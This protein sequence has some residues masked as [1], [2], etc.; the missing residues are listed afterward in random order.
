M[1]E[2]SDPI[3]HP[4]IYRTIIFAFAVWGAHFIASY[5]GVL[6]FP[7]SLVARLIAIVALIVAAAALAVR[8]WSL[9]KPR[10]PL[11]LGALWL[12]LAAIVFGTFP[13][14]VG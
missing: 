2:R 14:L 10:A 6:I 9:T 11:A 13:A 8:A 3:S 7:G 1:V 5:A 12:A 4:A